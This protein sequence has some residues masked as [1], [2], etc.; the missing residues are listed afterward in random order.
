[1]NSI[2]YIYKK[3][4]EFMVLGQG[5]TRMEHLE[6]SSNGWKHIH[7]IDA[8]LILHKIL[9]TTSELELCNIINDLK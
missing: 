8:T 2:V 7:T 9:N 3:G 1:M 6:L 4:T 5:D